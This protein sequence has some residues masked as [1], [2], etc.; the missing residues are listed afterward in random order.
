MG[1]VI[2]FSFHR[3]DEDFEVRVIARS[4]EPWFVLNDVCRVLGIANARHAA[5]RL[6]D[7]EKDDVALSDAIGRAQDT[8]VISEQGLYRLVLRS[9]KPQAAEFQDWVVGEVLPSIRKTGS[10]HSVAMPTQDTLL[11]RITIAVETQAQAVG[12]LATDVVTVKTDVVWIKDEQK[13]QGIRLK[14]VESIV[15]EATPR[16]R[17]FIKGTERTHCRCI[18]EIF[19]GLCPVCNKCEIV[20]C[21]GVLLK[22][23]HKEHF[24]AVNKP[25]LYHTWLICLECHGRRHKFPADYFDPDFNNYQQKLRRFIDPAYNQ[26]DMFRRVA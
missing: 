15:R 14:A 18:L 16:R 8:T 25:D 26:L 22:T 11:E 24:K 13:N 12:Y 21:D 1:D 4:G 23:G 20:S 9:D 7:C 10:Y 17:L 19:H 3:D 6:R 5:T 2:P